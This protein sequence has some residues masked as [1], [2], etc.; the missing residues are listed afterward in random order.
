MEVNGG[1]FSLSGSGR[2]IVNVSGRLKAQVSE[3]GSIRYEAK[4]STRV[5]SKVVGS[6]SIRE[7]KSR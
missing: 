5:V 6:G 3:S 2:M 1:D 4:P 7:I